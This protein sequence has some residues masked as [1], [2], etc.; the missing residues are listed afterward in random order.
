M[1]E[2][3]LSRLSTTH[4]CQSRATNMPST[5]D[6]EKRWGVGG[7]GVGAR[8]GWGGGGIGGGGEWG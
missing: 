4:Q 2:S 1:L 8:V 7:V 5:Q 6:K 3:G